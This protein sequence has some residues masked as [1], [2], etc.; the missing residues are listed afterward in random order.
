MLSISNPDF[1]PL[2]HNFPYFM[3]MFLLEWHFKTYDGI[4]V[5]HWNFLI[6]KSKLMDESAYRNVSHSYHKYWLHFTIFFLLWLNKSYIYR[7]KYGDNFIE[8]D[9]SLW[10]Y[11]CLLPCFLLVFYGFLFLYFVFDLPRNYFGKRGKIFP[12]Y[13]IRW[14]PCCPNQ[15]HS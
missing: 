11:K 1:A 4:K 13:F 2:D 14:L 12:W 6:C 15:I 5:A 8:R 3:G 10:G 7:N 9:S